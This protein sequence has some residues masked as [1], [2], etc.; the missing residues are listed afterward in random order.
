AGTLEEAELG[1]PPG[2]AQ[3]LDRRQ[4]VLLGVM[5][6]RD[7]V[8]GG[9]AGVELR[10]PAE[11]LADVDIVRSVVF[12]EARQRWGGTKAQNVDG[13]VLLRARRSAEIVNQDAV[14]DGA[15]D[16]RPGLVMVGVDEARH[17]HLAARIDLGCAARAQVRPDGEDLLALDQHVGL[18]KV[19]NFRVHRHHRAAADDVATAALAAVFRPVVVVRRGR[20]RREQACSG[21]SGPSRRGGLQEIA[22][23]EMVLRISVLAKDAHFGFL[24]RWSSGMT[25]L[26]SFCYCFGRTY[27]STRAA[28]LQ[29]DDED[30]TAVG[31]ESVPEPA[32]RVRPGASRLPSCPSCA[33]PPSRRRRRSRRRA[34]RTRAFRWDGLRPEA[35][36]RTGSVQRRP[37]AGR[38]GQRVN[39]SW[40]TPLWTFRTVCTRVPVAALTRVLPRNPQKA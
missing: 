19:S 23:P 36:G 6:L 12:G 40:Q 18:R 11:Q 21:R 20:T 33:T 3:S 7:V 30:G 34:R 26:G 32:P 5:D 25:T 14:G 2:I 22:P 4:G 8:H 9:D 13:V 17:D 39:V 37:G 27:T 29:C 28:L 1:A 10:K 24:P 31:R 15:S 16:R 35:R 38:A